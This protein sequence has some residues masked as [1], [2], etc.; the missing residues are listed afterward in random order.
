MQALKLQG[1]ARQAEGSWLE[2]VA[3]GQAAGQAGSKAEKGRA[4]GRGGGLLRAHQCGPGLPGLANSNWD[5]F[6][7][8]HFCFVWT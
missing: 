3:G 5:R 6:R 2:Q 7:K 4:E 8:H 1:E